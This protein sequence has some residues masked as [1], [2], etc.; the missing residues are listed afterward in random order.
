MGDKIANKPKIFNVN[1]F[2]TDDEGHFIW[3]GFGDNMRVLDW[4]IDRCEDK[5]DAV[6]T[7]IGFVP[8]AE[9]IN[10]EGLEDVTTDTIKELLSIDV[11]NWK[12]EAEGIEA[13]YKELGDRVPQELYNQLANLKANLDK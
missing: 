3:P 11:E 5:V 10:V 8:K 9:D 6:E 4:I 1:W 2:R 12:K 13:F 7:P